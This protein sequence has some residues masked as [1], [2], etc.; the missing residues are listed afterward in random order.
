MH[1]WR[2]QK[3]LRTLVPVLLLLI[4]LCGLMLK[5]RGIGDGRSFVADEAYAN[6]A[7]ATHLVEDRCYGFSSEAAIPA[8]HDTLWRLL[9]AWLAI[10]VRDPVSASYLAGAL[11]AVITLLVLVRLARLLF[12]F[13]PFILYA[14]VLLIVSPGFLLDI[15]GG[16]SQ[17]LATVLITAACLFHI[18]G[19]GRRGGYFLCHAGIKAVFAEQGLFFTTGY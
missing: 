18:E 7:V 3:I 11:C 12:P 10:L 14:S 6:L 16:T 13:P 19:I 1:R 5:Q 8:T 4:L 9:V 15:V 2:F 17:P